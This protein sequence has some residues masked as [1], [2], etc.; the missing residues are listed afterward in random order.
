MCVASRGPLDDAITMAPLRFWD[1]DR[2]DREPDYATIWQRLTSN[3]VLEVTSRVNPDRD[4]ELQR[5]GYGSHF[6]PRMAFRAGPS[7]GSPGFGAA[8]IHGLGIPDRQNLTESRVDCALSSWF[9]PSLWQPGGNVQ[10]AREHPLPDD[11]PLGSQGR[12]G[13]GF[14]TR[15]STGRS[16]TC[17]RR[18]VLVFE[19]AMIRDG[20]LSQW[21]RA[22]I[23]SPAG[24]STGL[25]RWEWIP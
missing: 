6:I 3:L 4:V 18:R 12:K 20:D 16:G 15:R 11:H 22:S 1:P 10:E 25:G 21:Y 2:M 7:S 9:W 23:R 13:N 17:T 24:A 8:G 14:L 19:E 5:K